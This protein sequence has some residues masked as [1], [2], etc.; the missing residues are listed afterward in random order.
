MLMMLIKYK[1][2]GGILMIDSV[3]IDEYMNELEKANVQKPNSPSKDS[4]SENELD[5]NHDSEDPIIDSEV[6]C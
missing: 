2:R 4:E 6:Y 5:D 1:P 3:D